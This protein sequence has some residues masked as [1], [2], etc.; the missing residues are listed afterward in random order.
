MTV[1]AQHNEILFGVV[2]QPA[3]RAKVVDL[4]ILRHAAVLAAPPIV[5]EHLAGEPAVGLGFK[6]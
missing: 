2:S 3:A 6:P 4:K 5:R 1:H